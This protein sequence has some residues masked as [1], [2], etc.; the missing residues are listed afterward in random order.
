MRRRPRCAADSALQPLLTGRR[1]CAPLPV[2]DVRDADPNMVD[3][4]RAATGKTTLLVL[5]SS[6]LKATNGRSLHFLDAAGRNLP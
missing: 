1:L 5:G 4:R 3:A 2:Q 6:L